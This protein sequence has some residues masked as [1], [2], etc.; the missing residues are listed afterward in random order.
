VETVRRLR[1]AD[2]F[3]W[4]DPLDFHLQP[5]LSRLH[6]D[7]TPQ[8]CRSELML[9]EPNG[10]VSGGFGVFRRLSVHLPLMLPLAVPAHLPGVGWMGTR[11]YRWVAARRGLLH[12][13]PACVTNQ[14]AVAISEN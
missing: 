7:L 12:R 3:G 11:V 8:R 10:R 2:V 5:D 9:V 1:A 6:P 13:G 14:C 4:L